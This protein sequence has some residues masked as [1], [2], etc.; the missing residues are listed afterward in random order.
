[1]THDILMQ[2]YGIQPQHYDKKT[3]SKLQGKRLIVS[4]KGVLPC[5]GKV[6]E[7]EERKQQWSLIPGIECKHCD[8]R[9][10]SLVLSYPS[11]WTQGVIKV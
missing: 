10:R 1:M 9:V 3:E 11:E 7:P 2:D 5:K 4:R 8:Q 6:L